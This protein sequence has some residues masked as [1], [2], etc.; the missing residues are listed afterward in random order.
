MDACELTRQ[1]HCHSVYLWPSCLP[2]GLSALL[3]HFLSPFSTQMP[4][5]CSRKLLCPSTSRP[6][7]FLPYLFHNA[8]HCLFHCMYTGQWLLICLYHPLNYNHS[9]EFGELVYLF[10]QLPAESMAHILSSMCVC[11]S[12]C[13]CV[14]VHELNASQDFGSNTG[15]VTNLGLP[16]ARCPIFP[17]PHH[18]H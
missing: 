11:I 17:S 3:L 4:I 9:G 6:P 14:C 13:V 18:P 12:V 5:L 2:I 7:A 16:T 15:S 10:P 8:L 1:E